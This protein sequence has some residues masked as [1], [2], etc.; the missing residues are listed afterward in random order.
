MTP[1]Q[2]LRVR[3][4]LA[5]ALALKPK[6]R[7]AFLDRA[8]ASDPLLRR[9]VETLLS[10][11]D[12]VR[13][14]FLQS[15]ESR[16]ALTSGAR[17]GDYEVVKLVGSGGM[18]EVYRARDARLERD[19]AI[20]VLPALLSRDPE[21]LRRF[22]QE[23][24]AAAALNHPN[25]LS[26]FQ[27]GTYEGAPYL[28]GEL[29]EGGTLR[30]AQARGPLAIRKAI[31]YGVQTARGLAAAH[32]KGIVHRD[33]K[34]ENLFITRDG[35]VKILDFGLAK[36]TQRQS[37]ADS[38]APTQTEGTE[39]GVVL[40]TVGY[41]SPEQVSG[42][43]ADHRA[44][45][46]AL[47]AI[48]YEMLAGRRAFQK[49]T[50][51]ETMTAILND[52]PPAISQ[53]VP[54]IPPALQRIVH[55][56]LEKDPDQR[57]HSA[58]DLG[59][60]LE[61]LS[62]SGISSNTAKA[63]DNS[64]RVIPWAIAAASILG[65]AIAVATVLYMRSP[66]KVGDRTNW[67]QLTNF[68]DS[69]TQPALSPDG[70][71]LTFVRGVSTFVDT[72][73]IY[74]KLLPSGEPVQLTHDNMLKMGPVFSPDGSRIAYT[75]LAA[76][77]WDTWVVPVL[78]GHVK[79]WLPNASGLVWTSPQHLMFSEIKSGEHM[80]I[81]TA[82]ESRGE[83]R[84]IYV[85][86]GNRGMAHRSYLSPDGKWALLVEMDNGEWLPC[87]VVPFSG[88]Y[89]GN[90]VGLANA[91]CTSG[92][93]SP[94]GKWIYLSLHT[95]ETFH[96]WRQRFPEGQPE[97]ITL[98]PT[99]EEGIALAPDGSS[100]ITSVGLRQRTISVHD[101]NGDHR[102]SLEGYAY[103]PYLSPDEKTV[104]YRILKG[105]T[106]PFLGASELWVADTGSERNEPLLPGFAVTGY[107]LSKDGTRVVFSALDSDGK[108]RLWIASTDRTG[109]P[110]QIPNVEGDMPYFL[111]P[112]EVVFHAIEGNSTFAFRVR[113]DGTE[114]RKLTSGQV[115]QVVGVSSDSRLVIGDSETNGRYKLKAFPASGDPPVPILDGL[116]F[117]RWTP[118]QRFLYF[119]VG[120]G[121]NSA[122]AYGHTY[123]IPLPADQMFPPIPPDGFHSE[124][125]IA[126]LPGVRVI[127]GG[128]VFPGSTPGTYAFSRQ[129]VQRNLY[130]I[131]LR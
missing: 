77:N 34:P 89:S 83:S 60:A 39:P 120:S 47:G 124:A 49:P 63:Q 93:W 100:L 31:D 8:C 45:I 42:R 22:E 65:L 102:I 81:V 119:S 18:G 61:A 111:P 36:L 69:V 85:P 59:F 107:D 92:A 88:G 51:A 54:L 128:D 114:R 99:E 116:G 67:V 23:A 94:D 98:G 20:K 80:A 48:L 70:R 91:P 76:F 125:E 75:G 103:W 44:D 25:I 106:S 127:E 6:D 27:M 26:V 35:R 71:M 78:A 52:D 90:R 11:N 79:R 55:R 95:G 86:P 113:E 105:G 74:I 24:R 43:R 38:N 13:S 50:S 40:G 112:G 7:P 28:V 87:R 97:Q 96:I 19:V 101:A 1:E 118:D 123:V 108:G 3:E 117:L 33:L 58:S 29:L 109:A 115:T 9:E 82:T 57:F 121:M 37:A 66:T 2:W 16:I 46:F 110:R 131:P 30:E 72:G 14:S 17:L 84:D 4:V 104:Y 5:E 73:E 126:A 62:D 21:R 12:E 64:R 53:I 122:R 129:T 130:R 32:E 15:S 10:S 41:M 68:P 56:C